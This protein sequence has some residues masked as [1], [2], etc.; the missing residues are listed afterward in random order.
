MPLGSMHD[1]AAGQPGQPE[2]AGAVAAALAGGLTIGGEW[3]LSLSSLT[4]GRQG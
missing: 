3:R 4:L 2:A 1:V